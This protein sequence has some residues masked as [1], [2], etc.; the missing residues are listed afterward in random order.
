VIGAGLSIKK[1]FTHFYVYFFNNIL[2]HTEEH[3][4]LQRLRYWSLHIPDDINKQSYM[5][6]ERLHVR[7]VS[8]DGKQVRDMYDQSAEVLLAGHGGNCRVGPLEAT[9]LRAYCEK[10]HTRQ[11]HMELWLAWGAMVRSKYEAAPPYD[12]DNKKAAL[13]KRF[14][15]TKKK[16]LSIVTSMVIE[17]TSSSNGLTGV[18]GLDD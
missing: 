17:E 8:C 15:S 4:F 14:S 16:R 3:Q 5:W 7:G 11:Y 12:G 18:L 6:V 1:H 10:N 2:T 13:V 9:E